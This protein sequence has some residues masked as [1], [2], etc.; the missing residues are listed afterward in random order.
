LTQVG[1]RIAMDL[2]GTKI[3]AARIDA[4]RIIERRQFAT[5]RDDIEST[6]IPA[7]Q[8]LIADWLPLTQGSIGV[9]TT[10]F[11]QGG[12]VSAV[13][14]A[15]FPFPMRFDL[16]GRLSGA[17]HRNVVVVNDG[18]AAAWGEY[19]AGAGKDD[20]G[21][22]FDSLA[23]LTVSTGVGGGLVSNGRLLT[24]PTGFAGH[25]GHVSIDRNGPPCGC[26]RIGC[27]EAIASGSAI[28]AKAS[29]LLGRFCDAAD[30]IASTDV[31]MTK[32]VDEAARAIASL[33]QNLK[34]LIDVETIV[35]GGSVGLNPVFLAATQSANAL[36][37]AAYQVPILPALCGPD[38]G[39][40]GVADLVA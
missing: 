40:I 20:Q 16:G 2:G 19:V 18:Q 26:G 8:A 13:N 24:G 32:I 5:P 11:A 9:A 28:S 1:P 7:M 4:H 29:A 35:L 31:R 10:G 30:V 34:A 17:S 36:A 23:F 27:V 37:P 33:C 21:K 12:F 3:A 25:A 39:L 38:A 6:L 15:T 14:P 22:A